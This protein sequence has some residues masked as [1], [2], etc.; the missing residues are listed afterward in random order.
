MEA[1]RVFEKSVGVRLRLRVCVSDGVDVGGGVWLRVADGVHVSEKESTAL[2]ERRDGD[3]E[4]DRLVRV[5][6]SKVTESD[7]LCVQ[8][9]Q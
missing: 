8:G 7:L 5:K 6:V 4:G 1:I 3:N 2:R 9:P